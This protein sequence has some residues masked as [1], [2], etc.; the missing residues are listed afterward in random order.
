MSIEPVVLNLQVSSI[1]AASEDA[2][3]GLGHNT[4]NL[5]R[6][7]NTEPVGKLHQYLNKKWGLADHG[8]DLSLFCRGAKMD[9]TDKLSMYMETSVSTKV[10]VEYQIVS[11][12]D[13]AA[14][15][16]STPMASPSGVESVLNEIQNLA[17]LNPPKPATAT[18]SVRTHADITAPASAPR[19]P[20]F[21]PI[22][23]PL[24]I[25]AS[26]QQEGLFLST[27]P[28]P[29]VPTANAGLNDSRVE[30]VYKEMLDREKDIFLSILDSQARWLCQMQNQMMTTCLSVQERA[31]SGLMAQAHRSSVHSEDDSGTSRVDTKKQRKHK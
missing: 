15:A 16:S 30:A 8:F 11:T 20:E 10:P 9:V 18:P 6:L 14:T 12:S 23:L 22:S 7:M 26:S 25:A 21:A 29:P 31:L 19:T 24:S 13:E 4:K 5:M 3:K 17:Q 1:D 27:L 28:A 2:L